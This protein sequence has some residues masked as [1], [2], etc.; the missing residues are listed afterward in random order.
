MSS[1]DKYGASLLNKV[2]QK[3]EYDGVDKS[4]GAKHPP[5]LFTRDT[6]DSRSSMKQYSSGIKKTEKAM[7]RC[8]K[9]CACC[10]V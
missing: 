8:L 5:P 2:K 10:I 7:K 3:V 6:V 9:R 1:K 4:T